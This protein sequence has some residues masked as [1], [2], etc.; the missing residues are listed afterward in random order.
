MRYRLSELRASMFLRMMWLLSVALIVV[1]GMIPMPVALADIVD[2]DTSKAIAVAYDNSGSMSSG[3]D[4]WCTG[5]YS[6]EVLA[7]MLGSNDTLTVFPMRTEDDISVT[8]NVAGSEG[9]RNRVDTVHNS[10][11]GLGF[12]T[13]PEAAQQAYEYLLSSDADEKYLVITTDGKFNQGNGLDDV[14][15]TVSECEDSKI[16]VLYL[17]I[18]D[19]VD[20]IESDGDNVVVKQVSDQDV[21]KTMTEF[22]N[23]IF[24]RAALPSTNYQT[25]DGMLTFDVPMQTLIVFAQGEGAKVGLLKG[26]DGT[27][28]APDAASV[29]YSEAPFKRISND[30]LTLS[31]TSPAALN[32]EYLDT[33]V[34]NEGLMGQVGVYTGPIP[35]G[36]F[37]LD[38][39]GADV[40][41]V[42]YKPYVDIATT[43]QSTTSDNQFELSS[44][45]EA[46]PLL[47][48]TYR[49]TSQAI[50]PS[51]G[52]PISSELLDG[53]S[54][55]TTIETNGVT[56][57]YDDG[58][59]VTLSV[60]DVRLSSTA[61]VPGGVRITK[62]YGTTH[63][64]A[65]MGSLNL[66]LEG[67]DDGVV[68]TS[69]GSEESKGTL[70]ITKENGDPISADEWASMEIVCKS[71]D[72]LE[73]E[74]EKGDVGTARVW[75]T[76]GNKT[77]D[78]TVSEL[79]GGFMPFARSFPTTVS[80]RI[81]D[82]DRPFA[83]SEK[84]E[85]SI[86]P[87]FVYII[88]H[89]WWAFALFAL[90]VTIIMLYALKPRL[91]KKMRISFTGDG[92]DAGFL[93]KHKN[94]KHKLL[95]LV[96]E[97][98][99][100]P[101]AH[102]I[103]FSA[104]VPVPVDLPNL[105][106]VAARG[107]RGCKGVAFHFDKKTCDALRAKEDRGTLGGFL[108]S[109]NTAYAVGHVFYGLY[110]PND[111]KHFVKQYQISF[112]RL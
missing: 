28:V 94:V 50:D 33:A 3:S 107:R 36:S 14:R 82:K 86:R 69:F 109:P 63:V 20:L 77:V 9:A 106:I 25:Q 70:S 66:S 93:Y 61:D 102:F 32:D 92:L 55:Y 34:V 96:P 58:A 103:G 57:A 48:D 19:D 79:L 89:Y 85:V 67:L 110:D 112:E 68:V 65:E 12:G 31:G 41:E 16:K 74:V 100:V 13:N 71:E 75:P 91:P 98:Y 22:A 84:L 80:A 37:K 42:Y 7:A 40:V 8:F 62:D 1:L 11:L 95:P 99:T 43:L 101:T 88:S 39:S 51:N 17:A 76:Y 59:E 90:L 30:A 5:K 73:W 97:Q 38:T 105:T 44:L 15:E 27:S 6:L 81:P 29:R 49:I 54:F 87:D 72:G 56:E 2:T 23:E 104:P 83:G 108:P 78:E 21:L 18:G 64:V 35:A 47:E 45:G 10:N 60:G 4:K 46:G 26:D 24:G 52:H 111:P 53:A